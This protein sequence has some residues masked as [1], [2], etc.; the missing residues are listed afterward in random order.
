MAIFN[1]PIKPKGDAE[2]L[3]TWILRLIPQMESFF[4]AYVHGVTIA[5]SETAVA[6]GQKYVPNMGIP[7]ART[8]VAVWQSK[9][10]D[11]RFCYFTAASSVV[12]DVKVCR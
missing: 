4:C 8:N 9:Q 12:I 1:F 11:E 10:P 2:T 7:V 3:W 6:H 5:T